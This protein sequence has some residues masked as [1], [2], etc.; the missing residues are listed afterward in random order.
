MGVMVTGLSDAGTGKRKGAYVFK[1]KATY[2]GEWLD[3]K[4]HGIGKYST[5][6]GEFYNGRWDSVSKSGFGETHQGL[7]GWK[8]HAD[9]SILAIDPHFFWKCDQLL[10]RDWQLMLC[11]GKTTTFPK[12]ELIITQG[13]K[14]TRM[15]KLVKGDLAIEKITDPEKPP[16]L[17]KVLQV[18]GDKPVILGETAVIPAIQEATANVRA[19]TEIEIIEVDIKLLFNIFASEPGVA[20]RFYRWVAQSIAEKIRQSHPKSAPTAAK[21]IDDDS[22]EEELIRPDH[23]SPDS[24]KKRNK[25][26]KGPKVKAP[27]VVNYQ[28]KFNLGSGEV[29]LKQTPAKLQGWKDKAGTFFV[30]SNTLVFE[31]APVFGST[32][33]EN[34]SIDAITQ[35]NGDEKSEELKIDTK[36]KKYRLVLQKDYASIFSFTEKLYLDSIKNHESESSSSTVRPAFAAS[37]AK[38]HPGMTRTTSKSNMGKMRKIHTETL[39]ESTEAGI[40]MGP[41]DWTRL[42]EG[43][44]LAAY[45]K[46]DKIVE[47]GKKH[48]RI[49]HIATG[50]CD[51]S[52]DTPDGP[53]HLV[54]LPQDSVFGELT[55]LDPRNQQATASVIAGSDDCTVNIIEGSW[56][57]LLMVD[58]P[59]IAGR[60]YNYLCSILAKRLSERELEMQAEADKQKKLAKA[61]EDKHTA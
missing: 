43:A 19:H 33:H 18:S 31:Y 49:Y 22:S 41:D 39:T 42:I 54:S 58:H 52:K 44:T 47:E 7:S 4:I 37:D 45:R 26:D 3:G 60:F 2:K 5:P 12:G 27:V 35:L 51:I 36:H 57:N 16:L 24:K 17:L 59:Q 34:I 15:I 29:L 61:E 50:S 32:L 20:M 28:S 14:N 9:G 11:K 46:G 38:G 6:D 21:A 30:F 13:K 56:I 1:N 23:K 55:F 25:A 8:E 48:Q 40:N 10:D 53:R